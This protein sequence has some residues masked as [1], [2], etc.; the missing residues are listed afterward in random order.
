LHKI[1]TSRWRIIGGLAG[2]A[3]LPIHMLVSTESSA[4]IAALVLGMVAAIYVGFALS[5]GR[6]DVI[7]TE[8]FVASLFVLAAYCSVAISPWLAVLA[9]T[10]H[11]FWDFAHDHGVKTVMPRWYIPFCA[12]YDYAFASGLAAIIFWKG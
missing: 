6:P 3:S 8:L 4:I 5:D 11:G 7:R 12:I 1:S 10:L 9:F 2:I